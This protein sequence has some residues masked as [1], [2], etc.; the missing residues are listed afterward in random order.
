MENLIK[1]TSHKNCK[2]GKNNKALLVSQICE[3]SAEHCKDQ[4][5]I[6]DIKT[7]DAFYII[8]STSE[9]T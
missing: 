3:N 1:T 9:N 6:N 4:N 7:N 2:P 8:Y 5:W